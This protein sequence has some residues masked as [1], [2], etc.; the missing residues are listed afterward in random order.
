MNA[1]LLILLSVSRT[2]GLMV[3]ASWCMVLKHV[4]WLVDLVNVEALLFAQRWSGQYVNRIPSA[5][6]KPGETPLQVGVYRLPHPVEKFS[7]G[8][9][10]LQ[11]E[12]GGWRTKE[13][14][15]N[16][17]NGSCAGAQNCAIASTVTFL[18]IP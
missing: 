6:Q 9:P 14:H 11:S 7:G 2:T 17:E 18:Y 8:L 5:S 10:R 4:V 15:S 1:R 13:N 16:T 3:F 12:Y